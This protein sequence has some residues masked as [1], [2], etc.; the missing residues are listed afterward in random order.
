MEGTVNKD[1]VCKSSSQYHP[2]SEIKS[3]SDETETTRDS[4]IGKSPYHTEKNIFDSYFSRSQKPKI[5]II[6][7]YRI[8][9][10]E[11]VD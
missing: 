10:C 11:N 4:R 7:V 2:I 8:S 9:F 5:L 6:F 3:N 1:Y